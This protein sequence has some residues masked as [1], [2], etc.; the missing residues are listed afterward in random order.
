M[1]NK[2][3]DLGLLGPTSWL[4]GRVTAFAGRL[5]GQGSAVRRAGTSGADA[6]RESEARTDAERSP[7]ISRASPGASPEL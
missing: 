1:V 2:R 3:I 5:K 6:M 7:T 4:Q